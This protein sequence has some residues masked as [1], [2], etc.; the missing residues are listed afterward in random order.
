MIYFTGGFLKLL[1]FAIGFSRLLC[2][3]A[4]LATFIYLIEIIEL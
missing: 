4:V 2:F 3:M 1:L